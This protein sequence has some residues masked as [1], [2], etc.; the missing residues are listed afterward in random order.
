M[1]SD[2]KVVVGGWSQSGGAQYC[3]AARFSEAGILDT[4]TFGNVGTPQ[5]GTTYVPFSIS[6][7]IQYDQANGM[8]IQPDGKIVLGGYSCNGSVPPF[9]FSV[10]RLGG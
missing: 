6:G 8:I 2:G 5:A 7:Q 9:Y 3:S 1:Q 4:V 10:A